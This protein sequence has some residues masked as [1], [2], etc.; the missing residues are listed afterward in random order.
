MVCAF[1]NM[2]GISPRV[3]MHTFEGCYIWSGLSGLTHGYAQG[4]GLYLGAGLADSRRSTVSWESGD[5]KIAAYL[6]GIYHKGY[7]SFV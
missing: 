6:H 1:V 5:F 7:A 4:E 3:G 2:V